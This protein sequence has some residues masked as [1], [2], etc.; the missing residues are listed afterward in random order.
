MS[1]FHAIPQ[2]LQSHN[3]F[4]KMNDEMCTYMYPF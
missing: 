1:N 3:Y 2:L 4:S